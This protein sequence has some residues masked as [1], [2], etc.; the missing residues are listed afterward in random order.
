MLVV[1]LCALPASALR[2]PARPPLRA[3][4]PAAAAATAATALLQAPIAA[5]AD[6]GFLGY[7]SQQEFWVEFN[8]PPIELRPFHVNLFGYLLVGGYAAYIAWTILRPPSEAEA[9][10]N[11]KVAEEGVAAAE[12]AGPFLKEAAAAEGARA[13]GSG[14]VFREVSA[15]TGT[16]PTKDSMVRVHYEGK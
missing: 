1:V 12:A 10:Y 6:D 5:V 8:K 13:L 4:A 2:L 14:L 15:G 16:A 11:A 3:S 7:A 9:A